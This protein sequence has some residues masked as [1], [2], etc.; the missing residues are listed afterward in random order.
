MFAVLTAATC[1]GLILLTT[2]LH[3]AT[4]GATV[5]VESVR[6]VEEAQIDLLL[7]QQA[8]NPLVRKQL[9]TE[10]RRRLDGTRQFIGSARERDAFEDA[11]QRVD[12]YFT[13]TTTDPSIVA[14]SQAAAYGA[15]DAL[16]DLNVADAHA[17]QQNATTWARLADVIGLGVGAI[18]LVTATTALVWLQHRA[19]VPI[20]HLAAAMERFA[21]GDVNARASEEGPRELREICRRY[22]DMATAL[23]AQRR[24]QIA[25]LGGVAHDLR[26][27][28]SVLKMAVSMV[29]A[30]RP[31][32]P[33]SMIRKMIATMTRQIARLERMVKDFLD[34]A[35]IEAGELELRKEAHDVRGIVSAVVPLF[36]ADAS[37][38]TIDVQVPEAPVVV[39]CDELRMEQVLTNLIS[40]AIKYSPDDAPVTVAVAEN[41]REVAVS[42]VDHGVGISEEERRRLFEP[43]RRVG[44][45]KE[46]VPGVGLGLFV[47]KQIV[48]A[49][50]G[51]IEIESAPGEG[52][53]FRVLLPAA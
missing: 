45:S 39:E 19:F 41:E 2:A 6:L 4:D 1:G 11:S 21:N 50:H 36:A 28:L 22:N 10:V 17:A 27:P 40:N 7:H 20:E 9:E 26:N 5:A 18:V 32:P 47:V 48:D 13:L 33:D 12:A 23:A 16:V 51:R 46:A 37:A 49:H 42:V 24:S 44:L 38:R 25:F 34:T 8:T 35:S 3:R 53:T 52:S 14:A 29:P 43:F 31:L 30:E 15:L